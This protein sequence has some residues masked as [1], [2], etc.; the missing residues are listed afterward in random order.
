M[1]ASRLA[2]ADHSNQAIFSKL[3][4]KH[5]NNTQRGMQMSM[6]NPVCPTWR[7]PLPSACRGLT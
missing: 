1:R 5:A 2:G 3:T 7:P 6:P 4:Q